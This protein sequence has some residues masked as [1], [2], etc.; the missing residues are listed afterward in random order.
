MLE[1]YMDAR[2]RRR[3]LKSRNVTTDALHGGEEFAAVRV[4]FKE[5]VLKKT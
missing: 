4:S 3:M 2:R 1:V 5:T